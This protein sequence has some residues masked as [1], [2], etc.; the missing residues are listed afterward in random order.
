MRWRI[1]AWVSLGAN[2]LL[3]AL[4]VL[5]RSQPGDKVAPEPATAVAPASA[6]TNLVVRRQF[7]SWREVE[8]PDYPTYIDNLRSI[9]CP[10][11]TIRDII[12]ADVNALY[13]KKRATEVVTAEQQWWRSQPDTNLLQVAAEKLH[14]LDEERRALL[15]HLLGSSWE[16]GDLVNLPRPSRPGI[17]LDGP[18][19]G[20]LSAD[21]KQALEDVSM[22]SADQLQ[23]YLAAQQAQGKSP[24]PAELAKLR[25]QTRAELERLLTPSQLEEFLLRY[26]QHANNLRGL[27]GQMEYFDASQDEFRSVFRATDSIDEQ[28]EALVG[29]DANTALQRKNLQDQRETAIKNALGSDRYEEYQMLQDPLYRDAVATALQAGTP[30]AAESIYEIN[31]ATLAEQQRIQSDTNLTADQKSIEL[32]QAELDQLKANTVAT[33]QDLPPDQTPQPQQPPPRKVYVLGPGDSATTISMM[34]GLPIIALRAANPNLD[35]G[36]LKPGD[37]VT[38]PRSPLGQ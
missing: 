4:W 17:A 38:I 16:M 10:E 6:K 18:V 22:R 32:K 3:V 8:A 9:G 25:Q 11:Q 37:S 33:G 19:L 20:T 1:V 30:D 29:N 15:S 2:C 21:T 14:A 27:F 5:T 26:S 7:F 13:A 34:Y 12:I 36:H 23:A 35:L 24:D 28:L 31:L